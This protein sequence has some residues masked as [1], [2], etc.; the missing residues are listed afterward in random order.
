MGIRLLGTSGFQA[1]EIEGLGLKWRRHVANFEACEIM[2]ATSIVNST[3]R[4]SCGAEPNQ[5]IA[6]EPR[7]LA[8]LA[9]FAPRL[10]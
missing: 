4:S 7:A 8:D 1:E 10:A 2:R 5:V 6:P 9:D 3:G